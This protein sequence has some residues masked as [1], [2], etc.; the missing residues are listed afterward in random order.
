MID[1]KVLN[2]REAADYIGVSQSTLKRWRDRGEGPPCHVLSTRIV[3]YRL[4]EVERWLTGQR[5]G[6]DGF[7]RVEG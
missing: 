4:H 1:G 6:G 3:R 5:V 7:D 2:Q